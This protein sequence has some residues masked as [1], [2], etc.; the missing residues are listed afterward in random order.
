MTGVQT[1][2]LPICDRLLA[3]ELVH[4]V[5]QRSTFQIAQKQA[6]TDTPLVS[7][8]S[9][10]H[11][12]RMIACP[13]A[14][15][16]TDPVPEGWRLYPGP[17]SV[18]HCG[19]RTI[20]E[21]RTP[22]V[23]DPMNECVYDHSGVL[24]DDRHPYAGCKGT[25]DQYGT[26]TILDKILHTACDTGGIVREGLPAF[27]ASR[28]YQVHQAI[29]G[30]TIIP[31]FLKSVLYSGTT[32]ALMVIHFL[33]FRSTLNIVISIRIACALYDLLMAAIRLGSEIIEDLLR[34]LTAAA[35][36]GLNSVIRVIAAG[37]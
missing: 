34:R 37:L 12:Q 32:A 30:S 27:I 9:N 2:A 23:D 17:T 22:T 21:N 3:H 24:V 18:F 16:D 29:A 36:F 26:S 10:L 35:A 7:S 6:V 13:T 19:F 5:Q 31:T 8:T 4:T 20:L 11:I 1:C 28:E 25:P 15:L 14:L 33:L